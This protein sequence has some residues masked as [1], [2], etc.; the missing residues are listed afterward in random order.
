MVRL[1]GCEVYANKYGYEADFYTITTPSK[2][3]PVHHNGIANDKFDGTTPREAQ[4]YLT[5]N[6]VLIRSAADRQKLD[7]FGIRVTEPHHDGTPHWHMLIFV[8][9]EH[10]QT[11]QEIVR[12]YALRED[13]DEKGAQTYRFKVDPIIKSKGSAVGY[14]A[15]YISKNID[16]FGLDKDSHGNNPIEKALRVRE[17]ASLHGIRQFQHFGSPPVILWREARRFILTIEQ[18]VMTPLWQAANDSDWC[19]FMEALGGVNVK[20]KDL[21][22]TVYREFIAQEGE[23]WEPIGFVVK[24]LQCGSEIYISREHQWKLR[25]K[26][27][28]LLGLSENEV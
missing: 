22:V 15:K 21:N 11:M 10:R 27:A 6:W 4:T 12:H 9:P 23:Y 25:K 14:I 28:P 19:A 24:G 26:K 3:H 20:R 16:G 5:N 13:G 1:H 18:D 8:K 7:Y 2:M 17:W